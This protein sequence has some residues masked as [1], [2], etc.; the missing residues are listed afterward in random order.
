MNAHHLT[1]YFMY[2]VLNFEFHIWMNVM[3]K[4]T[5]VYIH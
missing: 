4:E 1:L 3:A 5:F 2:F